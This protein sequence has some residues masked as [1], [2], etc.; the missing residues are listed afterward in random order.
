L[1]WRF[2]D[3]GVAGEAEE[4]PKSALLFTVGDLVPP[5]HLDRYSSLHS[6]DLCFTC[7]LV[8]S[9][10]QLLLAATPFSH[11]R[12]TIES[13]TRARVEDR[14]H[15]QHRSASKQYQD[16]RATE[17]AVSANAAGSTSVGHKADLNPIKVIPTGT[18]SV[19]RH[20]GWARGRAAVLA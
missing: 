1:R 6:D 2:G 19:E 15:W 17:W 20:C 11:A 9:E 13:V 3:T 5:F 16:S 7:S 18:F 14:R 12:S 8:P 4:P 10:P